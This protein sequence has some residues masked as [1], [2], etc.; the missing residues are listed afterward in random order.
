[1]KNDVGPKIDAAFETM[2]K[3]YLDCAKKSYADLEKQMEKVKSVFVQKYEKVIEKR[4]K[5]SYKQEKSI[6]DKMELLKTNLMIINSMD[7]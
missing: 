7:N 4:I 5:E 3:H 2:E 1:M 6:N